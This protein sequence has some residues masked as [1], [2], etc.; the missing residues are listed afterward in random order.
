MNT[1]NNLARNVD[2]PLSRTRE[3]VGVRAEH[4]IVGDTR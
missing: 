1:L 3:K 2:G 4:L